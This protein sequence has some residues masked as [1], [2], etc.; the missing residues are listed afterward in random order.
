MLAN[1]HIENY[2][3]IEH[4]EMLPSPRLNIIT[5]ET[6]AG[7]SIMLGA[8]GLLL[9]NRADSKALLNSDKKCVIEGEFEISNYNLENLFDS[10]ELDYDDIS[11]FR[12]EISPTGKSRAF[13]NDTPVTLEVLKAIG[14]YLMDVHSQNDTLMLANESFQVQVIDSYAGNHKLVDRYRIQFEKHK[15]ISKK[16]DEMIAD[17]N[18]YIKQSDYDNYLLQE[19]IDANLEIGEQERLEEQVGIFDNAEEIKFNLNGALQSL[20]QSDLNIIGMLQSVKLQLTHLARLSHHY[21]ELDQRLKGNLIELGDI[22]NEIEREELNVEFDP[23]KAEEYKERLSLIFNLEQ[24]HSVSSI[25][26]LLIIQSE[27]Q[28]KSES[29]LNLEEDIARIEEEKG[30]VYREM[31]EIAGELS[32]ARSRVFVKIE[33][34]INT[35]LKDLGM[36]DARLVIESETVPVGSNGIDKISI[37][38]S[39]N[40]GI[41]PQ[42]LGK[43]A[44]GGEFSR[45]M[46]CIKYILADKTSLPTIVFDEIDT[47]IAG[48][49]ALKMGKMID[50]MAHSHQ[51]I[52]ITHLPQ[53]AARGNKHFFVFKDSSD[54]K[55]KSI[56]RTLDEEE[57]TLEIAKMIGG[58]TPSAAAYKSANELLINQ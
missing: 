3:L 53:I 58:D 26:Q 33:N 36:A 49:I 30:Q 45:L 55:A 20:T 21:Q 16:L 17:R 41:A 25:E 47:G 28:T 12:R 39:A 9:G 42:N 18:N 19:L 1:L 11:I 5:G 35:L 13:I 6:G 24:K 4:L 10:H 54:K 37:L 14:S 29:G 51:V 31:L 52:T 48:E 8:V 32:A 7:K 38:F 50:K 56:M 27:L 22:A 2:A 43:V 44:S 40:K 57:R 23:Q 34:E 15:K 46:F